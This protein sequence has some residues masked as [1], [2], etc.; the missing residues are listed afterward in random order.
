[1]HQLLV[2]FVRSL[3]RRRFRIIAVFLMTPLSPSQCGEKRWRWNIISRS[4]TEVLG[5]GRKHCQ[6][7]KDLLLR[8]QDA[9]RDYAHGQFIL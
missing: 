6:G 9:N 5:E 4:G 7:H 2:R 8:G 1:M 3:F